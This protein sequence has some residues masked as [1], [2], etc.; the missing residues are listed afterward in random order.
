[1]EISS[2]PKCALLGLQHFFSSSTNVV[3]SILSV[4]GQ[5]YKIPV[6]DKNFI[7]FATVAMITEI[8]FFFNFHSDHC[9]GNK[10]LQ[11]IYAAYQSNCTSKNGVRQIKINKEKF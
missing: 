9:Y 3:I 7:L 8:V 10:F 5:M 4:L 2:F 6:F 11:H 1:M